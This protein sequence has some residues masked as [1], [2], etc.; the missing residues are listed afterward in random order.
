M[1]DAR[2]Q[3]NMAIADS[4]NMNPC[5]HEDD[6]LIEIPDTYDFREDENRKACVQSV[7]STGNCTAG[8][9]MAVISTVED[10]MCVLKES[11]ETF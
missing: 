1:N 7:R 10:R 3:F 6:K 4:P 2:L 9:V 8:H 11:T 5:K